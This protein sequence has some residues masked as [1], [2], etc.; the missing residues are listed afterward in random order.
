M[1]AQFQVDAIKFRKSL[2]IFA[3]DLLNTNWKSRI[4][5]HSQAPV[6]LYKED[7]YV[8]ELYNFSLI[9]AWSKVRKPKFA[10]HNTRIET[11][12]EKPTWKRPFLNNHCL[13]PITDFIEPIYEGKFAGNMV[14]FELEECVFVPAI[15][16][17]WTDKET[18]EV[19]FS[20]SI[21]T[22]EPNKI[23][24]RIGHDRSPV[25]IKQNIKTFDNWFDIENNNGDKFIEFLS[26][27]YEPKMKA[28]IDR[29]M[30]SGWEKRK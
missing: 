27:Q 23:V 25:F 15:Y 1:C 7:K 3:L 11:V 13:V 28:I 19:I 26:K 8:L 24:K 12:L 10:T 9:P 17:H 20:F 18:G 16:D 22:S 5:P 4:L 14:K 2:A 21:L 30:K 29:P 6:I